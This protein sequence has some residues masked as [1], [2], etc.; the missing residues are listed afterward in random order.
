MPPRIVLDTNIIISALL[1]GGNPRLLLQ[2]AVKGKITAIIS[3]PLLAEL[4]DILIKKF[5]FQ[6]EKTELLERKLK[7]VCVLVHPKVSITV[8]KDDPDNRVLEAA[9]EGLCT[10]IVTGDKPLLR[11]KTYQNIRIVSVKEFLHLSG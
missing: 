11:L 5:H 8:L 9:Q 10:Y 6:K 3:L 2:S 1:F 4:S 7:K